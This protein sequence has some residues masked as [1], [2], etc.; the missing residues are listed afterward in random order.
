MNLGHERNP[1]TARSKSF[2]ITVSVHWV[3]QRAAA[4]LICLGAREQVVDELIDGPSL[5]AAREGGFCKI[6]LHVYGNQQPIVHALR[7]ERRNMP[8]LIF[9]IK[10]QDYL[11]M[12]VPSSNWMGEVLFVNPDRLLQK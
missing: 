9:S 5:T 12:A 4:S 2:G 8:S 6:S 3:V 11:T 1:P 7:W 10:Y